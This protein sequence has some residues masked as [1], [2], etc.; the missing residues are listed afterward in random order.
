MYKRT[1]AAV[2]LPKIASSAGIISVYIAGNSGVITGKTG[3]NNPQKG[4][5][6]CED[7]PLFLATGNQAAFPI[8]MS[9]SFA[10]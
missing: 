3:N 8:T 10:R 4:R 2:L 1:Q 7:R 9:A 5:Y 6:S